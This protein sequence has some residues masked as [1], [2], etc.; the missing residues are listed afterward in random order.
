MRMTDRV[1]RGGRGAAT[2]SATSATSRASARTTRSGTSRSSLEEI[3]AAA[4]G[5]RLAALRRGARMKVA[6]VVSGGA[7]NPTASGGALTAWT[8]LSHLLERGRRRHRR[9]AARPGALRADGRRRRGAARKAC[10][11]LGADVRA[12]RLLVDR[13][14]PRAPA[15]AA[16]PRAPRAAAARTRKLQPHLVDAPE[17]TRHRRRPRRGRRVG[18]PLGGARGHAAA[19]RRRASRPS[20]TRP[21]S[22]RWYRFRDE[23]PDP[24]ALRRVNRLQ[25]QAASRAAAARPPAE[26][27]RRPRR[28][29]RAPRRLAPRSAARATAAY[30]R[31]PVPDPRPALASPRRQAA[32]LLLVGHLKGVVTLDGLRLFADGILPRLEARARPRRLRGADR[33]RLRAAARARARARPAVGSLPRPRRG[34][35][36]GVPPRARAARP[37]H[38]PA[39]DPRPDRDRLLVRDVRRLARREHARHPRARARAERAD[40]RLDADELAASTLRVLRDDA[41]RARLG[42]GARET[43]ERSFSP[44]VAAEAIATTLERIARPS[45]RTRAHAA[46]G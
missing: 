46:T 45:S 35:G 26:R 6:L 2:T 1:R 36:G 37:E 44:G 18:L 8:V 41:L 7:P 40:R 13:V 34:R 9:R 33:R 15:P 20:A 31:T 22:R 17:L 28:V 11:R 16:R 38:D 4:R 42:A 19:S 32:D 24:R 25:S 29:R 10:A 43:Y 23:L 27:V 39:R 30:L 21:C 3:F 14:L 5:S 12:G